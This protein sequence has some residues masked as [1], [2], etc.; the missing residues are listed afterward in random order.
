MAAGASGS[1]KNEVPGEKKKRKQ[2][3]RMGRAGGEGQM[4]DTHDEA[5]AESRKKEAKGRASYTSFRRE[6]RR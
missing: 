2:G 4:K 6:R 1:R 5:Q 3:G